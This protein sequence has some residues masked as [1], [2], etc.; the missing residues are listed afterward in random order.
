MKTENTPESIVSGTAPPLSVADGWAPIEQLPV[1]DKSN[2]DFC[3]IAWGPDD[4]KNTGL[5][6]RFGDE[7]FAS[8]IFYNGATHSKRQLVIREVRVQPTH[9]MPFPAFSDMPNAEAEEFSADSNLTH[10][11]PESQNKE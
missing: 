11:Q 7:W 4:V 3:L 9:Y 5:G 1:N 6:M 8:A 10:P 2:Y